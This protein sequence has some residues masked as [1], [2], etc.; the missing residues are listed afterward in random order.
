MTKL[1]CEH[2]FAALFLM[3]IFWILSAD[4]PLS[5]VT[6]GGAVLSCALQ[7]I[8]LVPVC[9]IS[10]NAKPAPKAYRAVCAVFYLYLS[11]RT[12]TRLLAVLEGIRVP[13]SSRPLA[14]C[15]LLLV[16]LY[17]A[18]VG[19]RALSRAGILL[20]GA[21]I[22]AFVV[23]LVGAVPDFSSAELIAAGTDGLLSAAWQDLCNSG[24]FVLCAALLMRQRHRTRAVY[25]ALLAQLAAAAAV[26]ILAIGV[27]GR[28]ISVA[29][30]PFFMLCA[31]SQPFSVQ[32]SDALFLLL[33]TAL[34]AFAAAYPLSLAVEVCRVLFPR[35]KGAAWWLTGAVL[36]GVWGLTAAQ[37]EAASVSAAAWLI[38]LT[39]IPCVRLVC[40][41]EGSDACANT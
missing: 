32:R 33:Y 1:K 5:S 21:T 37:T 31:F 9:M 8:L 35:C 28:L 24:G 29:D 25:A 36:L 27:L 14:L 23:L 26:T 22:I 39:I 12:L 13:V 15:L 3:K 16:C 7:A 18:V 6:L 38:L 40:R 19:L 34:G 41:K 2:L 20:L 30:H 11:V 4:A 17:G 10:S